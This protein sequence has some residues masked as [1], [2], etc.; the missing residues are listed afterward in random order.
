MEGE[1]QSN[2]LRNL[3]IWKKKKKLDDRQFGLRKQSSTIDAILK[4][5]IKIL[6]GFRRNKKTVAMFFDIEK[7]YDT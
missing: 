5:I 2:I 7:A 6:D 3:E 4:I 1:N